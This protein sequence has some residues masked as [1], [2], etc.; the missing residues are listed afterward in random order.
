MK[1]SEIFWYRA[2]KRWGLKLRER[3]KTTTG[4]IIKML[5]S[6]IVKLGPAL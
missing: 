3:N 6:T 5:A 4:L 1:I 2:I